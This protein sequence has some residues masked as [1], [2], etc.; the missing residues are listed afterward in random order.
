MKSVAKTID[1]T[2]KNVP[3]VPVTGANCAPLNGKEVP[4]LEV[5]WQI[6]PRRA[7]DKP[8]R[9]EVAWQASPEQTVPIIDL[10][11]KGAKAELPLM[12]A[13]PPPPIECCYL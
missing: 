7:S 6:S 2:G 3:G 8:V 9:L 11:A 4:H 5:S 12:P 13:V 1:A 10:T